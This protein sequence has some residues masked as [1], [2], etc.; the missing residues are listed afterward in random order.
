MKKINFSSGPAMLPRTVTESAAA[1]VLDLDGS[2][3]SILEIS[4]R[5]S[6]FTAILEETRHLIRTLLD[7]PDSYEPLFLTGGASTQFFMTAMNLLAPDEKAAFIDTGVWSAKA[8]A[9]AR[10]FGRVDVIA[11]SASEQYR[12]IPKSY[13]VPDDAVYLHFTS[14]N[15]IYGTQFHQWPVSEKNLVCDM[16]SDIFSRPFRIDPFGLIYA[17]AQKNLGPAGVTLVIV[18]KSWLDRIQPDLPAMLDYRTHVAKGSVY[19]TP[20]VFPI[21]VCLLTLRWLQ[22]EGGLAAMETR[23]QAKAGLLYAEI[24]RNPLFSGQVAPEDR[25][26]MNAT[27][28]ITAPELEQAFVAHCARAGIVGIKGHRSVGGFRASIYNAMPQSGVE[29]LIAEMQA[30]AHQYHFA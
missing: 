21:Y 22:A 28:T 5:G 7:L 20:P 1:A 23:N 13:T 9:E 30:F 3:L 18:K 29:R 2:G 24:D 11:S 4:H 14:N 17:G 12:F 10:R 25:S 8:I 6:A 19:N 15:T 27:F 26:L 16:S